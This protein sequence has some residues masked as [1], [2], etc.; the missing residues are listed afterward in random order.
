MT[1]SAV[2]KALQE[3]EATL[4][5]ALFDRTNRGVVPTIFG[6]RCRACAP[7]DRPARPCGR[8]DQGSERRH[9]RQD[10]GRHLAVGLG[11][12]PAAR[13]HGAAPAKAEARDVDHRGHER[14]PDAGATPRRARPRRRAASEFREREALLQEVL[15]MDIACV[16]VRP[17]HPLVERPALGLADLVE[18]DWILP[19]RETTLRRQL[20]QS[21]PRRRWSS[22]RRTPWNWC[23]YRRMA[24]CWRAAIISVRPGRPPRR[25]RR[26]SGSPFSGRAGATAKPRRGHDARR[27][28]AVSGG[29]DAAPD[30]ARRRQEIDTSPLLADI[31][32]EI[33]GLK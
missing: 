24:A 6:R 1:R 32:P 18:W 25:R 2:T 9:G 14:S 11:R 8:R 27:R 13:H 30:A 31:G 22:R 7:G 23:R 33:A 3:A 10:R 21:L 4:G 19:R 5:V 15:F 16:V 26:R 20:R 12:P 29:R 17:G 28:E